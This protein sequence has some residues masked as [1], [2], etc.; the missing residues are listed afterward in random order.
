M[1]ISIEPLGTG[2]FLPAVLL[3]WELAC[4]VERLVR[5][6]NAPPGFL[7]V[8]QQAGGYCMWYPECAGMLLRYEG[9]R[10]QFFR[11]PDE[12]IRG[13]KLMAED[14]DLGA[15]ARDFPILRRLVCTNGQPYEDGE[16]RQLN[17]LL[18]RSLRLPPIGG[19]VEGFLRFVDADVLSFFRRCHGL[20]CSLR[21]EDQRAGS[22]YQLNEGLAYY[23]EQRNRQ[24]V[25]LSDNIDVNEA[26]LAALASFGNTVGLN[27]PIRA[28]LLWENCD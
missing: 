28:F 7:H 17:A 23:I 15:L 18:A 4:T 8:A 2:I 6:G 14:P 25:L 26:T 13:F 24:D 21:P 12:L 19:G 9:N 1:L 16:L 5:R 3:G 20:Q 10:D 11:E 22:A 27:A